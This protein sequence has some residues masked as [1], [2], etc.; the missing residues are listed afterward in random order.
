MT[1]DRAATDPRLG[2]LTVGGA[3]VVLVGTFLP[4]LRSGDVWRNSYEV[5]RSADRLGVV[6][7]L[8]LQ[9]VHVAWFLVL[10]ATGLVLLA[11][12]LDRPAF[13]RAVAV[14]LAF[15]AAVAA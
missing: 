8:P 5:W 10:V 9:I 7:G 14:P 4:W 15:L 1:P 11:V 2:W 13:A 12:A 6:S 3:G